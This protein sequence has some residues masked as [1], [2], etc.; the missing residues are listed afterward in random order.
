[1][2]KCYLEPP[3]SELTWAA[4]HISDQ[5]EARIL[6][7]FRHGDEDVETPLPPPQM[8]PPPAGAGKRLDHVSS[9]VMSGRVRPENF[10]DV[11]EDGK[12]DSLVRALPPARYED[13]TLYRVTIQVVSKTSR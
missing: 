1:M 12:L 13:I 5:S 4:F 9:W 3:N 11:E 10:D 2:S 7:R 8:S 6:C